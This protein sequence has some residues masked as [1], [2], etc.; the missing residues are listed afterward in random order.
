LL[1]F[2]DKSVWKDEGASLYSARLSWTSLWHETLVVD[3]VLLPYY[4]LLHLWLDI[5]YNI[6]WA[7]ALSLLAYGLT[8]YVVG[9]LAYRVV[10]FWCALLAV[11]L[12]STNPLM[13]TSALDARPYALAALTAVL[14]VYALLE[15][16]DRGGPASLWV[17]SV[18][19]IATALLQLFAVLAPLSALAACV[20]LQLEKFR[21]DWRSV[22]PPI[23]SM[24]VVV[25]AFLASV[26]H[27]Q[28]QVAWIGGLNPKQFFEDLEGPASS[29]AGHLFYPAFVAALGFLSLVGIILAWIGRSFRPSRSEVDR[30]IVFLCVGIAPTIILVL[31]TAVKPIY[32]DRYV[33]ASAPGLT[34]A[35]ALL[36]SLS[37]RGL[38]TKASL[39]KRSVVA[40]AVLIGIAVLGVN[41]VTVSRSPLQDLKGA[42]QYI[43]QS[44]SPLSEVAVPGHFLATGVGYYLVRADS[45]LR[46]WPHL[47]GHRFN[48]VLDLNKNAKSFSSAA[49]SLW[50]VDDPSE[51][52][53]KGFIEDL[54]VHGFTRVSSTYF[55][56]VSVIHYLRHHKSL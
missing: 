14:S 9:L 37:L 51:S 44:A 29:A 50:L 5:S 43:I 42:T 15:W 10:G 26:A 41:S 16:F 55:Y 49:D 6:E 2:L 38:E 53:M 46:L 36:V 56:Q 28:G 35:V 40:G 17:F 13:I 25:V 54:R 8:V 3:R 31:I 33:T 32:V 18:L 45:S 4:A 48:D 22:L 23:M 21:R 24:M 11:V 19:T 27:Q 39:P 52:G 47:S 1:P 30:V 34:I 20:V 7:R 12:T